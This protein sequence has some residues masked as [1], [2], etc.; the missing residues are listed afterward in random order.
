MKQSLCFLFFGFTAGA[1]ISW[2]VAM[3]RVRMKILKRRKLLDRSLDHH[4]SARWLEVHNLLNDIFPKKVQDYSDS[5]DAGEI[6]IRAMLGGLMLAAVFYV[7]LLR[8]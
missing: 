2:A 1:T 3:T 7:I 8:Q 5:K 4:A 6:W